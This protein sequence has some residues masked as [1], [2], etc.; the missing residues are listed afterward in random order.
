[1]IRRLRS[2][3]LD[4]HAFERKAR[5]VSRS[6]PDRRFSSR[7][8]AP[9]PRH[10]SRERR[11]TR[12]RRAKR[13]TRATREEIDVVNAEIPEENI[14]KFVQYKKHGIFATEV[15]RVISIDEVPKISRRWEVVVQ[16]KVCII[17][18]DFCLYYVKVIRIR[19]NVLTINTFAILGINRYHK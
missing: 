7:S 12:G 4:R 5:S 9:V 6:R 15:C 17:S 1:M 19:Y 18:Q 3:S 13:D 14:N 2:K 16:V 10:E 11:D 8:R